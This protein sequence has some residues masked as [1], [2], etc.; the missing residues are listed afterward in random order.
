MRLHPGKGAPLVPDDSL[1]RIAL[2]PQIFIVQYELFF[3]RDK[4][5]YL[6]ICLR[7]MVPHSS[8]TYLGIK[9]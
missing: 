7:L 3:N 8:M 1:L 5:S 2:A 6:A 4:Y 9:L